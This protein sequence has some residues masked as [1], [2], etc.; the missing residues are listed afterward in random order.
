MGFL[1]VKYHIEMIYFDLINGLFLF[2]YDKE[3]VEMGNGNPCHH[4]STRFA[5]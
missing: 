3:N 1:A 5:R 4:M 2:T